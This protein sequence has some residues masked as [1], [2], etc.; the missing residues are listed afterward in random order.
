MNGVT[1][2]R[3]QEIEETKEVVKTMNVDAVASL[4]TNM[5]DKLHEVLADNVDL[6]RMVTDVKQGNIELRA[7][8]N[9]LKHMGF[10]GI[11]GHGSTVHNKEE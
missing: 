9:A 6:K 8:V 10:V 3:M 5:Q 1:P 4:L 11:T 2:E 7:E